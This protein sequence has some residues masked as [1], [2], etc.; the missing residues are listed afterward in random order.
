MY[1]TLRAWPVALKNKTAGIL[2]FSALKSRLFLFIY[3]GLFC[4]RVVRIRRLY[5]FRLNKLSSR[6][7]SFRVKA[8]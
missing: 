3:S 2:R 6:L 4:F 1:L 8:L 5:C 7:F